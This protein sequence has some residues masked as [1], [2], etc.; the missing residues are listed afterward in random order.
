MFHIK[1]LFIVIISFSLLALF[2][3]KKSGYDTS[4]TETEVDKS[5]MVTVDENNVTESNEDL[6]AVDYK[7]F[8]DELSSHGEWVQVSAQEVGLPTSSI[9]DNREQN[10]SLLHLLGVKNVYAGSSLNIDL[11][12]IFVWKPSDD[13]A[14][15]L[16]AG[17]PAATPVAYTP[18]SNGQWVYTDAGWYFQAPTVAE[19]ITSHYG[20]WAYTPDMGW[21]WLPGD[22]WAPAWVEW[23]ENPDYIAWTPAPPGTYIV[24]N[25]FSAPVIDDD[26]R[27]VVVE[28]KYFVEPAVYKYSYKYQ[29]KENKNKIMIKEMTKT[30][31]IMVKEKIVINKGPDVTVIERITGKKIEP[32][33]INRVSSPG[34]VKY[35]S[36]QI[37]TYAPK[38]MKVKSVEKVKNTPVSKPSKFRT[39]GEVKKTKQEKKE[40]GETKEKK[41]NKEIKK[42]EKE[43]GKEKGQEK[44]KGKEKG[45]D[46]GSNEKGKDK[47]NEKGNDKG[48]HGKGKK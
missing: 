8:Y 43:K 30:D 31:G 27:Y 12:T 23:R 34:D 41:E 5:E 7:P 45:K 28:K 2:S 46:K 4:K 1:S 10:Y 25:V 38:L 35:T 21:V 32:V 40:S 11:G 22:V 26:D 29:Y 24:N 44:E 14:V 36:T 37:N 17:E 48:D 42:E 3:C 47:G 19:E 9:I 13:L 15:S 6:V 16:T 20:R 33:K 39:A 18:Y